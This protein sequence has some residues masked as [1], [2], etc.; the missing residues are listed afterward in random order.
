MA[1]LPTPRRRFGGVS[2]LAI[3]I[4][5]VVLYALSRIQP[6]GPQRGSEAPPSVQ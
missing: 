3:F 2:L 6:R 1:R 4:V 5:L